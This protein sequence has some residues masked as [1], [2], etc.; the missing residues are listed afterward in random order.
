MPAKEEPIARKRHRAE[1]SGTAV[2][3]RLAVLV[4]ALF[5][6]VLAMLPSI[7]PALHIELNPAAPRTSYGVTLM[8]APQN[9]H[10]VQVPAVAQPVSPDK[11]PAT[12]TTANSASEAAVVLAE[13]ARLR[14]VLHAAPHIDQPTVVPFQGSFPTLVLPAAASAYTAQDLIQLGA[15]VPLPH[16]AAILV[17]N[18]Y[19]ATD[20]TLVL[21]GAALRTLY[22]ETGD[23]GFATIVG[24]GGNLT[25]SGTAAHP[26]TIMGW[27]RADNAPAADRGHGRSYI[28]EVD[29]RMTLTEVRAS[30]LGFWSGRTGG[31]AWTGLTSGPATGSAVDST[32]TGDTYGSF[33]S[34][35]SGIT[36]L[37]DLFEYNQLDGLHIHRYAVGTRAISSSAVR[38]GANGF[39][40]SPASEGT[41]LE[42]DIA[43]HNGGN[44]FYLNGRPLATGASASGVSVSPSTDTAVEYSAALDNVKIGVLVEGGRSTVVKG[45]QVCDSGSAIEVKDGAA[46]TVV[47]GNT[48]SCSPRS[49]ISVG[50]SA[51]GA[52]FAGNAIEG[53]RTGF[54]ISDSGGI[55]L[56]D[57][58]VTG[59]TLFGVDV[60]GATSAVSG[61]GNTIS[62]TGYQAVGY[63]ADAPAPSLDGSN[64]SGWTHHAR[65]AVWSYLRFHPLAAM[66][67][68][69][70]TLLLLASLWSRRRRAASHPYPAS[71]RWRSEGPQV[72]ATV[73]RLRLA[74]PAPPAWMTQPADTTRPTGTARP[75]DLTPPDGFRQ[76]AGLDITDPAPGI[77][78]AVADL[79]AAVAARG[80]P[81]PPWNTMPMP[82]LG[83]NQRRDDAPDPADAA[84]PPY[85]WPYRPRYDRRL[86]RRRSVER[87]R[88]DQADSR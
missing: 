76:P 74:R 66:W 27:D 87:S 61:V 54:L 81:R 48:I 15:L 41:L 24:W 88:G 21:G 18:V 79:A 8:V 49:G 77:A 25:F 45:N 6:A 65:I 64:V 83:R 51:Q 22:L 56:D 59:A 5:F 20:A 17:E 7:L 52:V 70:A 43:Q 28:R 23:K 31:V 14:A 35:G 60:R 16:D 46:E 71:T 53:A 84:D 78:A 58:R 11:P 4:C 62:G 85:E 68:G 32:F 67:L 44:G 12:A 42:N 10:A 3:A 80:G 39:T 26:M 37:D 36:F 29:G 57:N 13:D 19:V 30:W 73:G 72:T 50:P 9:P 40:V 33:V 69:I 34:R 63:R 86:A 47:T 55:Q 38:N 82:R 2:R 75:T 1:P